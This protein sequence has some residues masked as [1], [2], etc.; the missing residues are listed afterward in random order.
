MF[1]WKTRPFNVD[2]IDT[3][4]IFKDIWKQFLSIKWS[5]F[6]DEIAD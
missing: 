2:E 3:W 1:V 5:T 6:E 4:I